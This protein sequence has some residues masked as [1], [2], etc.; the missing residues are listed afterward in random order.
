MS[1]FFW[2]N[3]LTAS[4]TIVCVPVWLWCWWKRPR[5]MVL[6]MVLDGAW[7]IASDWYDGIW[8]KSRGLTSELGFWLDHGADFLFYGAVVLTLIKGSR[9]PEQKRKRRIEPPRRARA[10]SP[11]PAQPTD[12]APLPPTLP[13]TPPA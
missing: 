10:T 6:W 9:E 2:L 7:F 13:P 11:A 8:A 3:V 1:E 5:L 12:E 4:R